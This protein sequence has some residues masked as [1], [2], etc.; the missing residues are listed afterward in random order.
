M[1]LPNVAENLP[2]VASEKQ[3]R[4]ALNNTYHF[5]NIAVFEFY[6]GQTITP[7]PNVREAPN[8]SRTVRWIHTVDGGSHPLPV[9]YAFHTSTSNYSWWP[10]IDNFFKVQQMF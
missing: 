4:A 10:I 3:Q 1:E 9:L 8:L 5:L 2:R 7:E 6:F